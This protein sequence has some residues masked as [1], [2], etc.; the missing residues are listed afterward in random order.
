MRDRFSPVLVAVVL[1]LVAA[2]GLG[3]S[4]TAG[5]RVPDNSPEELER[6]IAEAARKPGP[7]LL[8]AGRPANGLP[9]TEIDSTGPPGTGL[10]VYGTCELPE[11]EG[12]CAPPVQIQHFAF[13]AGDW[14][15]A[16]GCSLREPIRGVPAAHHDSLVL[17]TG[18]RVV[19]IYARAPRAVASALRP[20]RGGTARGPLPP[21]PRSVL[22]LVREVCRSR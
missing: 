20:I 18:R 22:R 2:L 11:G 7:P 5:G 19:K 6:Q 17:F 8:W 14:R 21:P 9:V 4:G 10:V 1:A 13:R 3:C 16:T 15:R 12:G